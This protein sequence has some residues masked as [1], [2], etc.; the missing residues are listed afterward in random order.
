MYDLMCLLIRAWSLSIWIMMRSFLGWNLELLFPI[1]VV[2][3]LACWPLPRRTA[4]AAA[5]VRVPSVVEPGAARAKGRPSHVA[6]GVGAAPWLGAAAAVVTKGLHGAATAAAVA[7]VAA[8]VGA[9]GIVESGG[10]HDDA[11][12]FVGVDG[13]NRWAMRLVFSERS[14]VELLLRAWHPSHIYCWHRLEETER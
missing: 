9:P 4:A 1:T 8:D 13:G 3:S 14:G 10:R 5:G 6:G 11:S 12:S 2:G 7:V